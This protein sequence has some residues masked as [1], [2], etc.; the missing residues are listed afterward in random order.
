MVTVDSGAYNAVGPP[1]V[2]THFPIKHAEASKKGKNYTAANGSTIKNYGQ[3]VITG[4]NEHG[5]A[6]SVPIQIADVNKVFG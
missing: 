2:G 3:R 5:N 4:K 6:V 1:Q